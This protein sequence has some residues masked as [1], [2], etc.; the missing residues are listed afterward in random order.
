MQ[1]DAADDL[2][3]EM[4]HAQ[5]AGRRFPADRKSFRQ[6]AVQRLALILTSVLKLRRLGPQFLIRQSLHGLIIG[7]YFIC[8]LIELLN[9]FLVEI[10]ENH[11]HYTH[12]FP[13]FL[14]LLCL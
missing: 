12:I 13:L 4:L 3:V 8:D 9:L 6:Q 10:A 5:D 11:F 14:Y 7:F 1:R 2:H